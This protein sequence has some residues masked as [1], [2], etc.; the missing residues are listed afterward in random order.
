MEMKRI[1]KLDYDHGRKRKDSR[2]KINCKVVYGQR[3][4]R[5]LRQL[6]SYDQTFPLLENAQG[7]NKRKKVSVRMLTIERPVARLWG[8]A[9]NPEDTMSLASS[10]AS[11]KEF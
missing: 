10:S 7:M 2:I 1:Q 4:S 8:L 5:N 9:E 3:A 11:S 6:G